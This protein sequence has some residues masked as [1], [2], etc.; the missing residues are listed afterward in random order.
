M[1]KFLGNY[2][3]P[4]DIV[5]RLES[6]NPTESVDA[7]RHEPGLDASDFDKAV[8]RYYKG[9]SVLHRYHEDWMM[10]LLP[11]EFFVKNRLKKTKFMI[12]RAD[13]GQFTAPHRDRF[14]NTLKEHKQLVDKKFDSIVRLWVP[15]R[16]RQF[17]EAL[18]VENQ[19]LAEWKAG[20]VYTFGLD[21]LHSAC[22]AGLEPRYVLMGYCEKIQD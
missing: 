3:L 5:E 13:P 10:S 1:I 4:G 17:G 15:I 6:Q 19:T 8:Y 9:K 14:T 12:R 21:A 18:F 2:P 7:P 16:D 22:N 11:D 20:D